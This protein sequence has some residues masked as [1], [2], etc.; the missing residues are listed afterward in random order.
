MK[1][2]AVLLSILAIFHF[3][4]LSPPVTISQEIESL[5]ERSQ[6]D[7]KSNDYYNMIWKKIKEQWI[8]PENLW[9]EMVGLETI[10]VVIINR[11]GKIRRMWYEKKSGNPQY[12]QTAWEAIKKAEPFPPIPKEF[13][14]DTFYIGIRF[15]PD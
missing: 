8:I 13:A 10:I 14:D 9:K 15:H 6:I 5:K 3:V 12:D 2:L 11:S 7:S 1:R 4:A